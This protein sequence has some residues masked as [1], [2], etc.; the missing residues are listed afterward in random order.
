MYILERCKYLNAEPWKTKLDSRIEKLKEYKRQGFKLAIYLADKGDQFTFRYRAY[1][2]CQALDGSDTWRGLYFYGE[3]LEALEK[4]IQDIDLIILIRYG[5]TEE[6][7]RFFFLSKMLDKNV[8]FDVDDYIFDIEKLALLLESQGI[9]NPGK[10]ELE[11][12]IS[13]VSNM[14]KTAS[15]CDGYITTNAFLG[16]LLKETFGKNTYILENGF[17]YWQEQVST[18]YFYKKIESNQNI[19]EIVMGYFSGSN[20]HREDLKIAMNELIDLFYLFPKLKLRIVG[21]MELDKQMEQLQRENRIE[22]YPLQNFIE[23]QR[24]IA[25]VDI[26]LIPLVDNVFTNSK[27]ELKFFEAAICGTISCASPRYVYQNIIHNGEDGFLCDKGDWRRV[28]YSLC[29]NGISSD[30]VN[31]A[32][33]T[34]IEKY[35]FYNQ[36]PK[37]ENVLTKC[38]EGGGNI[39]RK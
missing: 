31:S 29:K 2:M 34:A 33:K 30:L 21:Y 3:E 36:R 8:I 19:D 15:L 22:F 24:L 27:S 18:Q 1:N 20:T 37:I 39:A 10:E 13:F 14:Q 38:H 32:R 11:Y 35:A 9:F 25:E 23:L 5:W 12:W 26:N 16:N 6:L 7:R 4:Y 17:N 28:I